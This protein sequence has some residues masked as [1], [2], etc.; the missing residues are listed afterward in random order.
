[1]GEKIAVGLGRIIEL[2]MGTNDAI[3]VKPI[4]V[5][6]VKIITTFTLIIECQGFN[7]KLR[8]TLS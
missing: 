8:M 4:I 2:R 3:G 7:S 5:T 1:M 6:F